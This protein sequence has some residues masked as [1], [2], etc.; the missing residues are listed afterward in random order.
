M[1]RRSGPPRAYS[2]YGLL[3]TRTDPNVPKHKGLTMF[4][5]DMRSRALRC[6]RSSRPTA[7]RNSTRSFHRRRHPGQPAPRR[8]GDGWKFADDAD[9]R[10]HVDRL[11]ASSA[12]AELFELGPDLNIDGRPALDDPATVG[13]R[14]SGEASGPSHQ[15]PAIS[16][17]S[18][19]E[20]PGRKTRSQAGGGTMMQEIAIYAMDLEGA[21]GAWT[22]AIGNR[23]AASFRL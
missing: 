19:G 11:K 20:P 21:A 23:A 10:A 15:L 18:R 4:F 7:C 12:F 17:L 14:A 3:I 13:W 6:G 8:G 16:S 22:A 1:A 2:D 5:L 9:E